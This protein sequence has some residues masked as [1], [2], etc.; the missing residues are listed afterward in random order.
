MKPK[1]L[2]EQVKTIN[3]SILRTLYPISTSVNNAITK[4]NWEQNSNLKIY[5]YHCSPFIQAEKNLD[6]KYSNKN[7]G[8]NL[9]NR[10]Y[11]VEILSHNNS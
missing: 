6:R 1:Q 9:H 5:I 11:V 7:Q 8:T 2:Q 4:P 10:S 3:K